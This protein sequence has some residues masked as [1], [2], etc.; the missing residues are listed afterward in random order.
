[1]DELSE[2]VKKD[3]KHLEEKGVEHVKKRDYLEIY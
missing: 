2:L 3:T 1:M